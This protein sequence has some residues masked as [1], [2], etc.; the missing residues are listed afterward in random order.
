PIE[1]AKRR[2]DASSPVVFDTLRGGVWTANGDVGTMSYVDVDARKVVQEVA[3]GTDVRSIALSPDGL[4]VAAVDRDLGTV[5][6][7]DAET[8][9]VRAKIPLGTHARGAIFDAWDPRWLYVGLED[10]SAI[11]LVDRSFG[12]LVRKIPIGRLPAGLAVSAT[13]HELAVTHRI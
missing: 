11:A 5:S 4:W 6:L 1:P 12:R 10:D 13:R 9:V 7:L 8:G 3:I 2:S